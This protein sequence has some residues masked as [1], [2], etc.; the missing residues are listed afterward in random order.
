MDAA[1]AAECASAEAE[2]RA[3]EGG[4]GAISARGFAASVGCDVA[5]AFTAAGTG[6]VFTARGAFAAG[7]A[8]SGFA[9]TTGALA[10]SAVRTAAFSACAAETCGSTDDAE[11]HDPP[12][13][14]AS[15]KSPAKTRAIDATVAGAGLRAAVGAGSPAVAALAI[16][17][18]RARR[19][20]PFTR[21]EIFFSE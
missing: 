4:T 13:S 15:R 3:G 6:N 5:F 16:E 14:V 1:A 8:V 18:P 12:A 2:G 20:A 17:R 11:G 7:E 19:R 10:T 9:R 21:S